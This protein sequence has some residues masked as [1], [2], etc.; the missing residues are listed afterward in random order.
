MILS[1]VFA[2]GLYLQVGQGGDQTLPTTPGSPAVSVP[3]IVNNGDHLGTTN[4]PITIPDQIP[5]TTQQ[6]VTTRPSDSPA[7]VQH[8]DT[9]AEIEAKA[10]IAGPAGVDETI[11][12]VGQGSEQV[13][14]QALD[15][16]DWFLNRD[17]KIILDDPAVQQLGNIMRLAALVLIA[18]GAG[19]V[20]LKHLAGPF[21]N[22]DPVLIQYALPTLLFFGLVGWYF[23]PI[24]GAA[25]DLVRALI[26]TIIATSLTEA[27]VPGFDL[28]GQMVDNI[29]GPLIFLFYVCVAALMVFKLGTQVGW[30]IILT[31]VAPIY[32]T[33]TGTPFLSRFGAQWWRSWFGTLLDPI[34]VVAGLRLVGPFVGFVG[35]PPPMIEELMRGFIL[36]AILR[37]PGFHAGAY[38]G[39]GADWMM[40]LLLSRLLRGHN[41]GAQLAVAGAERSGISITE[42]ATPARAAV[43]PMSLSSG[44]P[45]AGG[46]GS[47][48]N[49]WRWTPQ[50]VTPDSIW[51][52]MGRP[53]SSVSVHPPTTYGGFSNSSFSEVNHPETPDLEKQQ[54]SHPSASTQVAE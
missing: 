48:S 16:P 8:Q 36:L 14:R 54:V 40:G 23:E 52:G 10:R 24:L 27:I 4:P 22:T 21:V 53:S 5:G 7:P 42:V 43:Q 30:L 25:I 1:L 12:Q 39:S 45:S 17:R 18:I 37:A 9:P 32:I 28:L 38:G 35:H 34:L 13:V 31:A 29:I 2:I 49:S 41:G 44:S 6:P 15:V 51:A 3:S 19:L 11:R 50:P 46:S 33:I 20:F 47:F 26:G